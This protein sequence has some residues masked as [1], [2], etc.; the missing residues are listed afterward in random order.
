MD[1]F[2][3]GNKDIVNFEKTIYNSKLRGDVIIQLVSGAA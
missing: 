3:G 1:F 2:I